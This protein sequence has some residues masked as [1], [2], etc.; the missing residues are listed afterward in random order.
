MHASVWVFK[1]ERVMK[2]KVETSVV[3][4]TDARTGAF[5]MDLR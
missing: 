4:G 2:V 5:A 1:P 3:E